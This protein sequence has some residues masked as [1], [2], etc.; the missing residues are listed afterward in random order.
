VQG[1]DCRLNLTAAQVER[2]ASAEHRRWLASRAVAGWRFG[3]TRSD[4]E[5]L[6]PSMVSW[7]EL[8][9]A[10]RDT[11][12]DVIRQMPRVLHAAGLCLRPLYGVSVPRIRVSEQNANALVAEAREFAAAAGATP[13]LILALED[14]GGFRLA[15]RL[16]EISG[17]AVSFVLGQPMVG[18][19]IAAGLP[20]Q[21]AS[22]VAN[23][24][25]TLWITRPDALDAVLEGWPMLAG[26]TP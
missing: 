14:A 7:P 1:E 16:T 25:Q 22:Q 4:A 19:A 9:E 8:S 15:K 18:L 17:I 5:R 6:H 21:T 2:L 20:V 10:D 24:A 3:A 23:A 13:H 11:D 26:E 12:R